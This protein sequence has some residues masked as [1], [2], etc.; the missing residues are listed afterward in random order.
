MEQKMKALVVT[1]KE[2]VE[3]RDVSVPVP[4]DGELLVKIEACLICTWE[5]RIFKDGGGM[6][7]PFVPGHEI[8]GHVAA[9]PEGTITSFRVGDAVVVKTL[10][11]CGHCDFCYTGNDNL[12]AGKAKKR[13]YDGIPGSGGMAQYIAVSTARV[14]PMPDPAIDMAVAAFA[15]PLACCLRSVE[16]ADVRFGQDVVIVGGGIMGQLHNVLCQKR[17]ARVFM[18]ELDKARAALAARM[19]AIVMDPTAC[20]AVEEIKARTGGGAHA[21]FLTV[22]LTRLAQDYIAALRKMGKLVYYGSFH[23]DGDI[24]VNPNHIHYSEKTVTGSYSPTSEGF[25]TAARLIGLGIVDVKPFLTEMYPLSQA[26]TAFRRALSPET[27]RVGVRLW[28]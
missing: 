19:G 3:L 2:R 4:A 27:F 7:L 20:D 1:D 22:S 13:S 28:E 5:Q 23:P 11:S 21:V 17:G 24:A 10:D 12:C 16:H 26:D 8:A 25:Y 14:Y 15:E 18:V 6:K 9:V